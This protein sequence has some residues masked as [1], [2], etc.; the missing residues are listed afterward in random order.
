MRSLMKAE[1]THRRILAFADG[2]RRISNILQLSEL[3]HQA[4]R[5]NMLGMNETLRWLKKQQFNASSKETELRL[6]SDEDLVKI[7]TI[8]KS[9]GL[10]YPIVYCPYIGMSGGG[11][12]DKVFTF[13]KDGNAC[14]EIGSADHDEHKEIKA[15]EETAEDTRL[16]YVALTRAKY[17]CNVVCFTEAIYRSP[18]KSALG[19]LLSNGKTIKEDKAEFFVSYQLNLQNM[20]ASEASISLDSLPEYPSNLKYQNTENKQDLVA[21]EFKAIIKSQAQITSFSGLTAGC[22]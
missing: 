11:F 21:C 5:N 9:K 4:A 14:L 15:A 6:E 2:E 10:E 12:S 22:A 20:A 16:L 8:H 19:W 1:N 17:Q 7:V 3:I 18:D 13:H